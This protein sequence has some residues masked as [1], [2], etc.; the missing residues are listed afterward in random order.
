MVLLSRQPCAI[1]YAYAELVTFTAASFLDGDQSDNGVSFA[2]FVD[3]QPVPGV[4]SSATWSH[5]FR[6]PPGTQSRR[7]NYTV[8]VAATHI[9]GRSNRT[10]VLIR[11]AQDNNY[12]TPNVEQSQVGVI[13]FRRMLDG[14]PF[15]QQTAPNDR[16][17]FVESL[18]NCEMNTHATTGE[19]AR[20]IEISPR[21]FRWDR[22]A[23]ESMLRHELL[24]CRQF[25]WVCDSATFWHYLCIRGRGTTTEHLRMFMEC[26]AHLLYL[27]DASVS[28]K[29]LLEAGSI[30]SFLLNYAASC[31]AFN[32]LEHH[33]ELALEFLARCRITARQAFPELQHEDDYREANLACQKYSGSTPLQNPPEK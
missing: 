27:T 18:S 14:Q 33:R 23:F 20:V 12:G 7:H 13:R 22:E 1:I 31:L 6:P 4:G 2:W 10:E 8:A 28:Y 15:H 17:Q 26:E 16:L 24:H 29:F 3:G 19:L 32:D 11:V 21:A 25:S 5:S 30:D 9:G